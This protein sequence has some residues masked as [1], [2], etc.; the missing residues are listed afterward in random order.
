MVATP[1]VSS[2]FLVIPQSQ[3]DEKSVSENS[4]EDLTISKKKQR[5]KPIIR[6][7]RQSFRHLGAVNGSDS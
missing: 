1:A 4:N 2:Q 5:E 7:E 3:R 6:K